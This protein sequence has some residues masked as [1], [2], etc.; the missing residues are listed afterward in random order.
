MELKKIADNIWEIPMEGD[1]NVPGRIIANEKLLEQ[2]KSDKTIEQI[3]NVACMPGIYKFSIAMPDAHLGYGF[4]VGGVAAFDT[5]HGCITPGGVGFD[6]NC[7]VR[8]MTTGMLKQEVEP[9]I[10]E[11][12]EIMFKNIPCGVGRNSDI[13]LD[14]QE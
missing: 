4:C 2:I 3:K 1:M 9:K 13:R 6:I 8:L 7:G 12:L 5:K 10:K 11:L 14:D